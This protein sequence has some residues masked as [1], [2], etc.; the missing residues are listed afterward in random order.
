MF[1]ISVVCVIF[2]AVVTV[3]F[4]TYGGFEQR[5]E[6]LREGGELFHVLDLHVWRT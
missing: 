4:S 5:V 3:T 6:V 2:F 1:S